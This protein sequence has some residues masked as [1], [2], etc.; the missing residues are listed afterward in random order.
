MFAILALLLSSCTVYKFPYQ[1]TASVLDYSEYTNKG[2]F[3][4]ESN[5]VSFEYKALGSVSAV[6]TGGYEIVSSVERKNMQDDVYLSPETSKKV[7]YG[8]YKWASSKDALSTLCDK[9]MEVSANGVINIKI[10]YIPATYDSKTGSLASPDSY[11]I[12]G[13]AIRK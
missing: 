3:L 7:K 11:V 10:T 6:T 5:S 13:M 9:A 2:F 4:T 12:S 1:S 8:P